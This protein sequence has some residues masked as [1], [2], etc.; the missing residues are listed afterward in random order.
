MDRFASGALQFPTGFGVRI[1]WSVF[2][3]S[4]NITLRILCF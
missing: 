1:P 4:K 3:S 2:E